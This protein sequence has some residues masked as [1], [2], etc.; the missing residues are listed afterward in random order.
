MSNPPRYGKTLRIYIPEGIATGLRKVEIINW[1]GIAYACSRSKIDKLKL[2][3]EVKNAGVYLLIAEDEESPAG[4]QV[5]I[6]SSENVIRR[7]KQQMDEKD[8]WDQVIAFTSKDENLTKGHV[9]Y[10]E[11]RLINMLDEANMVSLLNTA[12]PVKNHIP[13]PD[14]AAMEEYLDNLLLIMG[15]LGYPNIHRQ[16]TASIIAS[17]S[18]LQDYTFNIHNIQ[19][20][21]NATMEIDDNGN[22]LVRS[23]AH[24]STEVSPSFDVM[25]GVKILR[26]RLIEQNKLELSPDGKYYILKEDTSF[27][28]PSYAGGFVQGRKC[29]GRTEWKTENN[30][31]L[32]D[33]EKDLLE[34]D[35]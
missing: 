20:H 29:N 1:T 22:Y 15:T 7:I 28:S 17:K 12:I 4:F 24:I 18:K 5:Y 33:I 13:E 23:G 30:K 2:R 31:A 35:H 34:L 3:K 8:F 27:Q 11:S 10:L 19:R 14:T 16:K 25:K 6:G 32:V 9:E 21:A 26:D